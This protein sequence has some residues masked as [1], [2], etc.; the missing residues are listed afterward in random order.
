MGE[1]KKIVCEFESSKGGLEG[2]KIKI[3]GQENNTN[4][5]LRK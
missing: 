4:N 1:E 5:R 3:T 2:N